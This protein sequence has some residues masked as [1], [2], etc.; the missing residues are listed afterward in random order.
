[1]SQNKILRFPTKKH[2][3]PC[4]KGMS[5]SEILF[6]YA[7]FIEYIARKIQMRL[8]AHIELDDLISCGA[9]GLIDAVKKYNPT[10]NIKFKTYAE[11]RIRGAI[12][13]EL[14]NQD[15][16]S[17]SVRE[18]VKKL[19]R[20]NQKLQSHLGRPPQPQEICEELEISIDAYYKLVDVTKV[21]QHVDIDEIYTT[22]ESVHIKTQRYSSNDYLK[23]SNPQSIVNFKVAKEKI[24][25]G[26]QGLPPKQQTILMMYYYEEL[27]LREIGNILKVT[28]ARISQLHSKA[29]KALKETFQTDFESITDLIAA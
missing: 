17:R 29:I 16:A 27:N 24:L 9:I 10:K 3:Y 28:D 18:K 23:S 14:R 6:R 15:W 5:R 7:P 13:D 11:T 25:E 8:P 12:L 26:I 4:V 19:D 20:V 21:V 1:M 2:R 22:N